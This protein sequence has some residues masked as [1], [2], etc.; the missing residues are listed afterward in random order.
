M[1]EGFEF[2]VVSNAPYTSVGTRDGDF[3]I[4]SAAQTPV[5]VRYSRAV[6]QDIRIEV[7][8]VFKLIR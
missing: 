1:P 8:P 4:W 6:L 7:N 3:A 2:S 5:V